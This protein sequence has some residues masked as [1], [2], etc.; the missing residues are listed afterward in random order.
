VAGGSFAFS[1][2]GTDAYTGGQNS[3]NANIDFAVRPGSADYPLVFWA[4]GKQGGGGSAWCGVAFGSVGG[5]GSVVAGSTMVYWGAAT[6]LS[7]LC[8]TAKTDAML[9]SVPINVSYG[10][11]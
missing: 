1:F 3:L 6:C 9:I 10:L 8:S 4:V 5:A 7:V 2:T 11:V